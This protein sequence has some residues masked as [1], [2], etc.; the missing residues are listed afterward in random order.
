MNRTNTQL[1]SDYTMDVTNQLHILNL[2]V[3]YNFLPAHSHHTLKLGVGPGFQIDMAKTIHTYLNEEGSL[4]Q[5]SNKTLYP[6]FAFGTEVS[7][8]W[9]FYK[10]LSVGT[11]VG[12][13]F[14]RAASQGNHFTVGLTLSASFTHR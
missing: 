7:Y 14:A 8:Q 10:C 2:Y 11:D 13:M 9:N 4:R 5:Q 1:S 6:Y 12:Y 3:S